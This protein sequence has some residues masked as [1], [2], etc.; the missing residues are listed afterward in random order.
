MLRLI[1]WLFLICV[2]LG[3]RA[4]HY[5]RAPSA[6]LYPRNHGGCYTS[7]A[8]YWYYH[9]Q[10]RMC[11]KTWNRCP[12]NPNNFRTKK[13]CRKT[14]ISSVPE[15]RACWQ[16]LDKGVDCHHCRRTHGCGEYRFYY[17]RRRRYCSRFYYYG[18]G[19]NS[20]NFRS[21]RACMCRCVHYKKWLKCKFWSKN[22][23]P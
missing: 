3:V 10:S 1:H 18:C 17:D 7:Y 21:R 2:G 13:A 8:P 6:C 22:Q 23:Q 20:N 16:P 4:G 19:G 11:R 9:F 12:R 5:P 14:C 15:Y